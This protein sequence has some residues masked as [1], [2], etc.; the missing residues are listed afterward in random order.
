MFLDY[1]LV[2]D[3]YP[4]ARALDYAFIGGLQ[5]LMSLVVTPLV[6]VSLRFWGMRATLSVGLI[7]LTA[8]LIG[9][10]F[11]TEVWQLFLSQGACFGLGIAF[12]YVGSSNIAPQWFSTKRSLANGITA[13][14][15]GFGGLVYSLASSY[16]LHQAGPPKTFRVIAI[17]EFVAN[18]VSIVLVKDRNK[19]QRPN[20]SAFNYKLLSR[21]EIWLVLGW[22]FMSELGYVVLLY[23][24]PNYAT[25]IGLNARQ[26]SIVGAMLNV[27][28][29]IGRPVIGHLGDTLGR[30]N[31][32]TLT[33]GF[34]GFICFIIWIF[35]TTFSV[36]CVFAILA[37]MVAGTFWSSI[38][39]VAVDV[40]GLVELP[41]TLSIVFVL[42]GAPS[43]CE[44]VIFSNNVI[45]AATPADYIFYSC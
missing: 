18:L 35:S 20:Q 37:G 38:A 13:A 4:K 16:L 36:L 17:C 19:T 14:G 32:T 41:S 43:T 7:F 1:Y 12:L 31:M 2:Q 45:G 24:L 33:T 10:S 6:N 15:A 26:G 11:A 5:I 34:C 39:P 3:F 40:A 8:S 25:H 27:G 21:L 22:G 42:M 29:M 28:L 9:A 23:S 30:I 44:F